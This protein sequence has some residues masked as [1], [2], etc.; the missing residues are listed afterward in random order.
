MKHG[1][2]AP[3]HE[4]GSRSGRRRNSAP[5]KT[6]SARR[7]SHPRDHGM[8]VG[9]VAE[10]SAPG[11]RNRSRPS[12]TLAC[13]TLPI[14]SGCR[15]PS[16]GRPAAGASDIRD[17]PVRSAS[18]SPPRAARSPASVE[19]AGRRRRFRAPGSSGNTT[20]TT[21][22]DPACGS[23]R[24][25]ARRRATARRSRRNRFSRASCR[26]AH[27][28]ARANQLRGNSS[29]QS[30]MYFPPKMPSRSISFGV[31]SG[32]NPGAKFRPTGSVRQ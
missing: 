27:S 28:L 19:S 26:S 15:M 20:G 23:I 4:A 17:R 11:R 24:C 22:V 12:R 2:G 14:S 29:W 6:P 21:H 16:E 8:P 25:D 9:L 13:H 3:S 31:R 30:V 1:A 7:R 5:Q 32:V 18:E 10:G